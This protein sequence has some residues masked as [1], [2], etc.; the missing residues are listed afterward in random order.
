MSDELT[1][2]ST[3]LAD[4]YAIER[5]L[6]AG[7]MATVYLARDLKHQRQVAIKVMRPEIAATMGS[8]R[9]LQ[10][11]QIASRLQHPHVLMLIDSGEADGFL[12]YVMPYVE[13]ESLAERLAREKQLPLKEAVRLTREIASALSSAHERGLI[14]RDIKPD[15]IML[16]GG[17]AVVMD[18]GIGRAISA[19][20][21]ARITETGFALGTPAY[22][23]PEQAAGDPDVDVRADVY[24][25][26]CVLYEMLAGEPPYTGATPQ[27]IV[28]KSLSAP[29][30]S[31]RH[32]RQSV[33]PAV[34]AVLSQALAKVPA[35]RFTTA[36]E[37]ASTLEQAV[38]D[39]GSL[40][41]PAQRPAR[42]RW[43]VA[44]MG[45]ALATMVAV[46]F[47]GGFWLTS[48]SSPA[49]RVDRLAVLPL[50]VMG[51]SVEDYLVSGIHDAL[52]TEL[53]KLGSVAVIART[54]MLRYAGS[55]KTVREIGDELS[56]D[57]I[58]EGSISKSVDGLRLSVNLI[59]A[60]TEVQRWGESYGVELGNAL[61]LQRRIAQTIGQEI[62][63]AEAAGPAVLAIEAAD[64]AVT[65][66]YLKGR[67]LLLRGTPGDLSSAREQLERTIA[68][69][70]GFAPA[71]AQLAIIYNNLAFLGETPPP[72]A[73]DRAKTAAREALALDD[74]L[75]DAHVQ[76]A[77][78][79]ATQDWDWAAAD[80]EYQRA[81]ELNPNLFEAHM[82]YGFHLA[83]LGRHDEARAAAQR[84]RELDPVQP[85]TI[86]NQAMVAFLGR[87]YDDAIAWAREV[88]DLEPN[89]IL[90]YD[91]LAQ[92]HEQQGE[93]AEAIA[94]VQRAREIF[95]GDARRSAIL[96][97]IY[98]RAGRTEEAR[99]VLDDLLAREGR[100]YVPPIALS[101]VYLGLGEKARA[102]D[103]LEATFRAREG[104][105]VMINTNPVYDPL[106]SEPRF[107]GLLRRMDFAP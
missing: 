22:M 18:F 73:F 104:D 1:R 62:S 87:R 102:L 51:D 72:V 53:A 96:G 56:V 81:I 43:R 3:A 99:A 98:A 92:A 52:I 88:I 64:P 19:V 95:D 105:V 6:G 57:A 103:W 50:V 47:A 76:L 13:G 78:A 49:I 84:A 7:G 12:Y 45:L 48:R 97:R 89:F 16:S 60:E 82:L 41:I 35:D 31:V 11:I 5:E 107:Q 59:E 67:F 30:P 74:G 20:G 17:H 68:L 46:V 79:L 71:Y 42:S 24:S 80:R 25:L 90:A 33:S 83:L 32:I 26:G 21:D 44:G 14:H 85:A 94:A 36:A 15:N 63:G 69:D 28:A 55:S 54:S 65:E 38:T 40:R 70:P 58:V 2:V 23:S 4:R 66:T 39:P 27:A 61:A 106:R 91:H 77:F 101:W 75:A 86:A 37:F 100:G 10:E 34:E 29:V 8:E 9:F 93:Y